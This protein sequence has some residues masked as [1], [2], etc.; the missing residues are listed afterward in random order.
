MVKRLSDMKKLS[1]AVVVAFHKYTP[2][3]DEFYEP[4]LDYFL[5]NMRK[6]ENEYDK[7]YLLDSTW[8]IDPKKI[9]GLK[10]EIVKVNPS[11]RY[12]D[13]YKQILPEIKEYL[14]L[15][16][17]NDM[18]V[19][20]EGVIKA[21]FDKLETDI[22]VV[23]IYDSIGT[24]TTPLLNGKN[25][26]CPYWFATGTLM[27]R[28]FLTVEWA[29]D[30]PYCETLGHLTEAM[31]KEKVIPYEWE[32]DKN[33]VLFDGTKDGEKGKNLGY[34][35][36]RAGST[37]A[38]LLATKKYG[39]IQTYKDYLKNQPKSELLRHCA[40]YQYILDKTYHPDAGWELLE[41]LKDMEVD[42]TDF[43]RYMSRFEEYHGL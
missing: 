37:P 15:F 26:F 13:A 28:D 32:E 40:W 33:N 8:N 41:M 30:M 36:I 6:Y 14:V 42:S 27:L 34:Y 23:S 9:E 38:Y 35:H 3:G 16:V 1:K 29:P 22:D 11:L 18:I 31:L 24:Y 17:D 5:K 25:K 10:A 21:T 20:K 12:Y 43:G 7:L 19:Y 4:I 2:F 39:D